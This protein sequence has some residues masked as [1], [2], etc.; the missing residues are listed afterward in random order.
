MFV[1]VMENF[2]TNGVT[3]EKISVENELDSRRC[4]IV[5]HFVFIGPV[6]DESLASLKYIVAQK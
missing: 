4:L 3:S 6:A 1:Y 5:I 2:A